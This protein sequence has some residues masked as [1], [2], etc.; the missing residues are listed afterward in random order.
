M[1][2]L[3]RARRHFLG[4]VSALVLPARLLREHH[5]GQEHA[6]PDPDLRERGILF[7]MAAIILWM[8]I[9]SPFFTRRT[10]ASTQNVLQLMQRPEALQRGRRAN[11]G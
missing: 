8:G 3:G 11:Q 7:V 10:E 2:G 6:L 9:G 4:R 1:G 5:K